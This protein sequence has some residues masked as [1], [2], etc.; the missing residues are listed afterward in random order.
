MGKCVI[1][2]ASVVMLAI[3]LAFCIIQ[4]PINIYAAGDAPDAN[5]ANGSTDKPYIINEESDFAFISTHMGAY[6]LQ[7]ADITLTGSWTIIGDNAASFIGTYNG[8]GH[9]ISNL[10]INDST[11]SFV[12][13]FGYTNNAVIKNVI[14]LGVSVNA[15]SGVGQAY[16]GAIVGMATGNTVIERCQVIGG[17]IKGTSNDYVGSMAGGSGSTTDA[18]RYCSNSAAI[19]AVDGEFVYAGGIAG[20]NNGA[21]AD[22]SNTGS[23]SGGEFGYA[24]GIAGYS[25]AGGNSVMRCYSTGNIST[26]VAYSYAGGIVGNASSTIL[27]D[28]YY[29]IDSAL[30][31]I[32]NM[33]FAGP[34]DDGCTY[35]D[36]IYLQNPGNYFNWNFAGNIW[37]IVPGVNN[38]YPVLK[39]VPTLVTTTAASNI[40]LMTATSGG[41]VTGT[42]YGTVISRGVQYCKGTDAISTAAAL[43]GGTG[44]YQVSLSGL[45]PDTSYY[46]KAYASNEVGTAYGEPVLFNTL[47]APPSVSTVGVPA[48]DIYTAGQSLNLT[49]N[50][51]KNV[52]VTGSPFLT[53]NIGTNTPVQAVYVGG[54][55]TISLVFRYTIASGDADTDGISIGSEITLNGGTIKDAAGNNAVLTLNGVGSTTGVLVDT[56]MP[57]ITS[58]SLSAGNG[59]MDITFSEGIYGAADGATALSPS[60]FVLIFTPHGGAVTSAA[61]SSVTQ[62]DG[63]PLFAGGQTAI[64]AYLTVTGTPSG[65]ETIEIMPA[66]GAAIYDK[67]GNAMTTAQTTGVKTFNDKEAPAAGGSGII[68]A[69]AGATTVGIG[70]TQATDTKTAQGNLQYQVVSSDTN[71]IDT[72]VNAE[73]NGAVVQSWTAA[74]YD[75]EATGLEQGTTYYFNIIVKDEAGNKAVYAMTQA[76]TTIPEI[77]ITGNAI[78]IVNGDTTPDSSDGTSFGSADIKT[79]SIERTFTLQN[80]GTG[81]LS[82]NGTTLVEITGAAA[83]DFAVTQ[84]PSETIAAGGSTTFKVT[85]DPS[86]EGTKTATISLANDDSDENP[87]SFDIQGT[88]TATPE[89]NVRGNATSIADGD[90]TPQSL[91][92]TDYGSIDIIGGTVEKTYTIE[93][94]GSAAV[95]LSGIPKVEIS[96][97]DASDFTVTQEP[98]GTIACDGSTSFTVTFDPSGIGTRTAGISI[99]NND[100]DENPYSFNITGIGTD[101]TAPAAGGSGIIAI[102]DATSNGLDISWTAATDDGTA[103]G[104]LEY[105][106]LYSETNE[107]ET[108]SDAVYNGTAVQDWEAGLTE[109]AIT[110]LSPETTYYMNVLVRDEAGNKAIY[111]MGTADTVE[112]DDTEAPEAGNSGRIETGNVTASSIDLE[113]DAATDN[114]TAQADLQYRVVYSKEDDIDTLNG[115]LN[116]GTEAQDWTAALTELT[117]DGL[118]SDTLYY[119]NVIAAD[120]A[121]NK[122]VYEAVY[123][124]TLAAEDTTSPE[125]GGAGVITVG[126]VTT[127]SV[128]LEWE[129]ATDDK[130]AAGGL[131]YKAV[132]SRS[133]NIGTVNDAQ[134]NG[135]VAQGWSSGLTELAITDL[136]DDTVYYFNVIVAD[137]AGNKTVYQE[138]LQ[139]TREK[140][141]SNDNDDDNKNTS[142]GSTTEI[143]VNGKTENAGTTTVTEEGNVTITTVTVNDQKIEAKLAQEGQ[144]AMVVIPVNGASDVVV[145][146]LNGQT[147]KN[148]EQKEAILEIRT[149]NVSYTLPASEINIDSIS[150]QIGQQVALKDIKISITIGEPSEETVRIVESTAVRDGYQIVVKPVEFGIS[151]TSGNKTVQVNKF[152]GYVERMV[153]IPE[154][155]DPS[156]ITT[157]VVLNSDGTFSHVPTTIVIVGGRYYAK[158]NSL[159]NSVYSVI[160]NPKTFRD[161]ENH[162]AKAEVN[163]MGSRLVING[164]DEDN[165][166]PDRE[167]TRGEFAAIVVKGLGLMRTGTGKDIYGDV[168]KNDW[169]YDA[170][171]IASE[172]R[173]IN[174]TGK[175]SFEPD[176]KITR[177]EAM[178]I[179]SRAMAIVKLDTDTSEAEIKQVLSGYKDSGKL[180]S[181]SEKSAAVCIKSGIIQGSGNAIRSEANITRA[182]SAA[183]VRRFLQKA[184][185]I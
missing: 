137:E 4:L 183:M 168:D 30:S 165:F 103:Q 86:T 111:Q 46:T 133:S 106:V 113:W 2:K 35:G 74:V 118:D 21:I 22:C 33:D 163:D 132:Y 76:T 42:G 40:A 92:N 51:D 52:T 128:S 173:L 175:G 90:T 154:G 60:K 5:G 135:T 69:T 134:N 34:S 147:I 88:A 98:S 45:V 169:Y 99:A 172:Y 110:G 112:A 68:T 174:G 116:N 18:I 95:T 151:C 122:T 10:T 161:V 107:L 24:G 78:T 3:V 65:I 117:A 77:N 49:V 178:L 176:R 13:M 89:I 31:G 58:A 8:N 166:A 73:A 84:E 141:R 136:D 72:L 6:F 37:T 149:E 17:T 64:R 138:T 11:H 120:E 43:S 160:W 81:A 104:S 26:G 32:G 66:T 48:N 105:M 171:Y 50:F 39:Q 180:N 54:S 170:V 56:L 87:Y 119:F 157:G 155:V 19:Q 143:I 1:N 29:H 123:E 126:Q 153:A 131:K 57:Q 36:S 121:G 152:N 61:V 93:S 158:I 9:T 75:A 27:D 177:E 80:T 150:E 130:T 67:A 96:G 101:S 71:N 179:M 108:I 142:P 185:L 167:I 53:L 184:K 62:S 23:I 182:E 20:L 83:A 159:T 16:I 162:W 181:W 91:D 140:E 15:G 100:S 38:G 148:M 59:Y 164:V 85:F 124:R 14:L 44:S 139:R 82:L 97:A 114:S 79:G 125:A 47:P 145:G 94:L 70:W 55:G 7:T 12:G 109:I 115:A 146:V 41:N 28:N 127:S 156:R 63:T 144:G 102:E 129:A 25:Y